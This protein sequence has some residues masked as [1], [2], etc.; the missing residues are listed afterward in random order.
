MA[1][2]HRADGLN[3]TM[4]TGN[5]ETHRQT[6]SSGI[7]TCFV[8]RPDNVVLHI[9]VDSKAD[10]QQLLNKVI[11]DLVSDCLHRYVLFWVF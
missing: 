6:S 10:G 3:S 2:A 11:A 4:P 5:A 1:L 9:D 7:I 8:T